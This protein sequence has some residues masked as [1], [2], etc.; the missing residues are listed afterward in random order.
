MSDTYKPTGTHSHLLIS[1]TSQQSLAFTNASIPPQPPFI[2]P[3][4]LHYCLTI[5]ITI[6]TSH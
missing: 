1:T 5:T 3:L 4:L 2:L 6:S